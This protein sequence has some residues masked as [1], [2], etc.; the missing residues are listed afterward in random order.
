MFTPVDSIPITSAKV[1]EIIVYLEDTKKV[2]DMQLEISDLQQR[3]AESEAK[4]L[5][6]HDLLIAEMSY[7]MRLKDKLEEYE[8]DIRNRTRDC[9]HK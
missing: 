1:H 3:L 6:F 2:K 9:D 7:S 5:K 4:V 8:R